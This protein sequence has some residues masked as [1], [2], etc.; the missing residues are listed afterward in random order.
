VQRL[1]EP[2]RGEVLAGLEPLVE[3][4]GR[5]QAVD[6]RRER[7]AGL[8]CRAYVARI[9]GQSIHISFTWL[10]NSTKS[11]NTFVPEKCG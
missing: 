5:L 4:L 7:L 11:R 6:D 8:V 9:S 1:V 10:G 2:G 3:G